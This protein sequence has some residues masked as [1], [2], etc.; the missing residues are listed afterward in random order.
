MSEES[1]AKIIRETKVVVLS[2]VKKHLFEHYAHALDD[3]VQETYFKAFDS[4]VKEKFREESKLSTWLYV[5]AKNEALR[6]NGKLKRE[7]QKKDLF[8]IF[9]REKEKE[10]DEKLNTLEIEDTLK[11]VNLLPLKYRSILMLYSEGLSEK[12][13]AEKLLLPSGTVKS[14]IYRGRKKMLRMLENGGT[15]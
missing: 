1:F 11:K 15:A 14:R 2:A 12:E 8:G 10:L 7:E 5:I 3:V 4:L 6:M 9:F 13:I